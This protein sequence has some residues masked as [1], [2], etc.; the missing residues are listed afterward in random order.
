MNLFRTKIWRWQEIAMLKWC[1]ILIGMIAGAHL[2]GFV[3]R[4]VW[5]FVLAALFL[6]IGPAVR[7][8]GRGGRTEAC[9]TAGDHSANDNGDRL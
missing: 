1:C 7:Y 3:V 2:S 5:G 6:A 9:G 4:Y 8:F